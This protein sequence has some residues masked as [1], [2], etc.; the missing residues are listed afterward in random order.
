MLA[1][2]H[3]HTR[4]SDGNASPEE[5]LEAAGTMGV[6]ELGI[7]DH[8]VH[9][10]D[11]IEIK[12]AMTTRQ[13]RGY[14][15]DIRALMMKS[16][17][18]GGPAV[19]LGLEVDWYP[20]HAAALHEALGGY[21]FDYLIGSVH[22][23]DGMLV[24]MSAAAWEKLSESQQNRVHRQY[25]LDMRSLAE[26]GLF[27]IAAHLDL[28]KKF[29]YLPTIDLSEERGAA[30]HAIA[31][32]GLVVELNTAGWHKPCEDAYPRLDILRDCHARGI[33]VTLSSDAHQPD[34]LLRDFKRG[35]QRL[36]EAG[37]T[38]VAR[39]AGRSKRFESIQSAFAGL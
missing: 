36:M 13:L 32:A 28:T 23:V 6:D 4:W 18:R 3:T 16:S 37:Y 17:E 20:G 22:E 14:V 26:S 21:A 5:L 35:A 39:F 15:H 30:L 34:H 10:P 27:D 38:E 12:W 31:E 19:R 7:S 33:P 11:G 2:Y 25:W 29:G 9:H 8:F 24:D 1:T